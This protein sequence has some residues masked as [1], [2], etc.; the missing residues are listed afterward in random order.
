MQGVVVQRLYMIA[1]TATLCGIV[2]MSFTQPVK[3]TTRPEEQAVLYAQVPAALDPKGRPPGPSPATGPG[4]A[5]AYMQV[6]RFGKNWLWTVVEGT[7]L[8]YLAEGPGH[9]TDTALM[10]ERGNLVVAGHRAGHGDPFID[11]DLLEDGDQITFRQSGAWWRYTV[12][13]E[14]EII[15]PSTVW[16]L[17]QP[18]ESRKLTLVTCW[19]K[20]GSEKR[21]FIRAKLTDWSGK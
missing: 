5:L 12:I 19:P 7:T 9:Y 14:P 18:H 2:W 8:E 20:Y 13:R 3:S 1:M 4:D 6:P 10:G 16:V 11:F 17:N 15:E 21:M